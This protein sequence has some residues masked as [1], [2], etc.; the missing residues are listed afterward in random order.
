MD[1]GAASRAVDLFVDGKL[2]AW[3]YVLEAPPRDVELSSRRKR[4]HRGVVGWQ[5]QAA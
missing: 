1:A 2:V 3:F 4:L 5:G